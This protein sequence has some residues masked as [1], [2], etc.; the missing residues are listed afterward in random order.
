[1][2]QLDTRK[3]QEERLAAER[4]QSEEQLKA[5]AEL[6]KREYAEKLAQEVRGSPSCAVKCGDQLI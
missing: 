5:T 1:M 6:H 3:E 2:T 4:R